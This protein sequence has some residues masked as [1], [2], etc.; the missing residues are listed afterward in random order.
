[1]TSEDRRTAKALRRDETDPVTRLGRIVY[2][3]RVLAV[4]AEAMADERLRIA[5]R[6][7]DG[8]ATRQWERLTGRRG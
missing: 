2:E 3:A 8:C 1:M 5:V 7:I 6:A 4:D